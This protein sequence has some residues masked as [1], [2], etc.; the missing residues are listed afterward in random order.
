MIKLKVNKGV[1]VGVSKEEK[2]W[3]TENL[4]QICKSLRKV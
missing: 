2:K 3:K 4:A 1:N